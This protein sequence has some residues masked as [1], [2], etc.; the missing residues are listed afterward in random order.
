MPISG[1][2]YFTLQNPGFIWF[3]SVRPFPLFSISARDIYL[4][5]K[6]NMLIKLLS[7]YTMGDSK[8]EEMDQ[9]H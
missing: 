9:E 3:A 4:E 6:G 1:E 2:E 8:G 7:I 5:G